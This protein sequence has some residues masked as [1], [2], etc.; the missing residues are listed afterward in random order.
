MKSRKEK[1]LL[2]ILKA[3]ERLT[4]PEG[5]ELGYANSDLLN[6]VMATYSLASYTIEKEGKTK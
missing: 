6:I 3:I 1:K 5:D 4:M 2:D